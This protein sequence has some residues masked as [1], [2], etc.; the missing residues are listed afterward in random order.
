MDKTRAGILG[1]LGVRESA[2]RQKSRHRAGVRMKVEIRKGHKRR[3]KMEGQV[4]VAL[5]VA[6]PV[7]LFPAAFVWYLSLGGVFAAAR[8][9]RTRRVAAK[10]PTK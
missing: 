7:I 9:A 4:I 8:E 2:E 5:V 10:A 6:I 3:T 1:V